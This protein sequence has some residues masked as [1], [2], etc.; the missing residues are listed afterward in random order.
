MRSVGGAGPTWTKRA[1]KRVFG[2]FS[3]LI[4][5]REKVRKT[6]FFALFVQV[7]PAPPTERISLED[8]Y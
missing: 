7:G 6:R 5:N 2:T 8:N 3:R 4:F 1:K